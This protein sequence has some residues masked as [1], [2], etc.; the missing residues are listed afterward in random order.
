M[1][2][3]DD[4]SISRRQALAAALVAV[5]VVAIAVWRATVGLSF[6]DDSYYVSVPWR[7]ASGA[8]LF[9]DEL[10]AQSLGELIS[11][12]F[13][14]AYRFAFGL[15]G[16]VLAL[17]LF[18]VALASGA[19]ALAY[20]LLRPSVRPLVIV[21]ALSLPLLAPP[22]HVLA[23]SY[24]TIAVLCFM[25]SVVAGFAAIRDSSWRLAAFAGVA[26]ALGA[27]SYPPFALGAVV[28]LVT[29]GVLGGWRLFLAMAAGA[30][31]AGVV[32]AASVLIAA[33]PASISH[34]LSYSRGSI[35]V[36]TTFGHK[37][38]MTLDRT[39]WA[40][41]RF[42]LLP[43]W[44]LAIAA[45]IPFGSA[46]FR[47]VALALIPVMAA[48]PGVLLLFAGDKITFGTAAPTW[49]I[50]AT[51]GLLIPASVWTFRAGRADLRR[52]L[53]LAAPFSATAYLTVALVTSSSW[54]RG[55]P[56]IGLVPLSIGLLL[57]WATA[58]AEDSGSITLAIGVATAL[59][60]VSGLLFAT[61]WADV[62]I[63]IPHAR[64]ASG[65]YA[66][67][68][69]GTARRDEVL[70]LTEAGKR[71][72]KPGSRVT[73]LGEREAYLLVGG[74][75]YTPLTWLLPSAPDSE[76]LNYYARNG[77]PADVVFVDDYGITKQGGTAK[78]ALKD[79]LYAY[80]LANYR[81]VD[82][83]AKFSVFVRP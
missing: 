31:A 58:L 41:S 71:L 63:W 32:F 45:S 46:R 55:L 67:I 21:V 70:A 39:A 16:I 37:L 6:Y 25:L 19:C 30:A 36:H 15:T 22:Y 8:R 64:V 4:S 26:A 10:S 80:V 18:Y 20:R 75:P 48:L 51:A 68:S 47:S 77:G 78:A 14:L 44:A 83:V 11:V 42:A 27:A 3:T 72:V 23:P 65:P 76:V 73:F 57:C 82:R 52:L 1:P 62:S 69:A 43:M 49:L 33:S 59:V 7:L 53:T 35:D 40:L 29:F 28:L 56:A 5:F 17:R 60:A 24:N 54:N 34:A 50:T 81:Q 79:P 61:A 38:Q 9:V 74:V 13:V 12:P 66:G 2:T